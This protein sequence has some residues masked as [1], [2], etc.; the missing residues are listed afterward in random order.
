MPRN[1]FTLSIRVSCEIHFLRAYILVSQ[2][3]NNFLFIIHVD[4]RRCKITTHIDTELIARQITQMPATGKDFKVFA[5]K[6]FNRLGLS[7]RFDDD[8]IFGIFRQGVQFFQRFSYR[9]IDTA[10]NNNLFFLSAFFLA[11]F[12]RIVYSNR[13][14]NGKFQHIYSS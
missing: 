5:E 9:Q 4:I 7:G 8:Q 2:F 12:F 11:A 14:L 1:S 10:F 6:L 13:S 3:L